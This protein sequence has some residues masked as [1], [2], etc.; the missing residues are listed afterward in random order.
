[1]GGFVLRSMFIP[2]ALHGVEASFIVGT[3]LRKLRAA[4]FG[5]YVV[6]SAAF[7]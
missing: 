3:S 7:C 4:F 1:M 2:G 6:S 5:S